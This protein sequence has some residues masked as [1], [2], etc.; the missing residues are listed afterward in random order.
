MSLPLKQG[1]C[2]IRD[3]HDSAMRRLPLQNWSVIVVWKTWRC[4]GNA[5]VQMHWSIF[6]FL[7]KHIFYIHLNWHVFAYLLTNSWQHFS[8][9]THRSMCVHISACL[10]TRFGAV[11]LYLSVIFL[12]CTPPM[13]INSFGDVPTDADNRINLHDPLPQRTSLTSF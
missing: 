8:S 10:Y 12:Q 11:I 3:V 9:Y 7:R 4:G 5:R 2:G 13:Y 1:T 6:V